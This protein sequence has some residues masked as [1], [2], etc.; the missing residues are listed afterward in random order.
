MCS[1]LPD[2]A[3][4]ALESALPHLAAEDRREDWDV[5]FYDAVATQDGANG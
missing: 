1:I 2:D 3:A 5:S 4:G